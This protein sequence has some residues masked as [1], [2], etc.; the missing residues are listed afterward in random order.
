M[1]KKITRQNKL[2]GYLTKRFQLTA[3]NAVKIR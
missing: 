1:Q 3:S 2:P